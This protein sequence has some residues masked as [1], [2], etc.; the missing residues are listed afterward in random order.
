MS[1]LEGLKAIFCFPALHFGG[2]ER[3]G[4]HFCRYLRDYEGVAVEVWGFFDGEGVK[5]RCAELN[6]PCHLV[7]LHLGKS[8]L[9]AL[10]GLFRLGYRIKK[11]GAKLLLPYVDY[12]NV[13]LG[14]I[15]PWTNAQFCWWQQR[16][17]GYSIGHKWLQ[18]IAIRNAPVFISNSSS[19]IDFLTDRLMVNESR[20]RFIPNGV[21]LPTPKE[22]RSKWRQHL[23]LGEGEFL[24]TMVANLTCK[25]DHLTLLKAWKE[26]L[27][28]NQSSKLPVLALA[29]RFGDTEKLVKAM[30]Y[31]L[32]IGRAVRFLGAV[33]DVDGLLL[34]S[35]LCVFSSQAEGCP[36][37][38][39]EAMANGLPVVATDITGV[40]DAVGQDARVHLAPI[41]D[42]T[43]L[44][45][46][47]QIMLERP[48]LRQIEGEKNRARIVSEFSIE[49]MCRASVE[50]IKTHLKKAY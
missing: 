49:K 5:E 32:E 21:G 36:N 38:I 29:G 34:A 3:Q 41:G 8:P 10:F 47:I 6:V 1:A 7:P 30:A 35:D 26:V 19:G 23:G 40:R 44:A 16:N 43:A 18:K 27:A 22:T 37:G 24:A 28:S 31:D 48:T 9:E 15:W 46:K 25:K 11:S 45:C 42:H 4:L 20:C 33:E 13:A 2:A 50:I 39:L 14:A 17:A 12:P